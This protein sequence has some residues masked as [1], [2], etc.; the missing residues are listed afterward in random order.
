MKNGFGLRKVL[1][2]TTAALLLL[3]GLGQAEDDG[4]ITGAQ[5]AIGQND[6]F[7][8]INI[9][10]ARARSEA[11]KALATELSQVEKDWGIKLYGLRRTAGGYMLEMKF[12][13]LDEN[14]AFPLLKRDIAHYL[15]VEKDGSVLEVPF[16]QKLGFMRASVRT[17]NMVKKDYN[18]SALFANPNK[19]VKLG[20]KVT[21]VL[22]NFI[23]ENL[24]VQ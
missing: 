1:V 22:G 11:S 14:K 10:K 17:S 3:G 6:A 2:C 15:I 24:A 19:H 16:T 23:F 13:V 20:D 9:E 8:M 4:S 18:Y 5:K 21:L 12:R 7:A